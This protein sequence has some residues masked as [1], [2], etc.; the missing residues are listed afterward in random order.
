MVLLALARREAA[1]KKSLLA[2]PRA[3]EESFVSPTT[4]SNSDHAAGF[5]LCTTPVGGDKDAC[6]SRDK[7]GSGQTRPV[8]SVVQVVGL[9]FA[10]EK[11][12]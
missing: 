2:G 7:I 10:R 3:R 9:L 8:A 12:F 11:H 6:E 1:E 4:A 5:S